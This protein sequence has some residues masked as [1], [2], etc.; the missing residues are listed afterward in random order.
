LNLG[1]IRAAPEWKELI[2]AQQK[3]SGQ[4]QGFRLVVEQVRKL[5]AS[6]AEHSLDRARKR[7]T[8]IYRQLTKRADF[9]SV[10][11][12]AQKKYAVEMSGNSSSQKVT[13]ILNQT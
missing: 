5:S 3:L 12:D 10:T 4:E 1:Q 11:M 7:I 9:P 13:A 6:L 2:R 8:T